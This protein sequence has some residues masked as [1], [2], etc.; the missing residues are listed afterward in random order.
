MTSFRPLVVLALAAVWLA[1]RPASAAPAEIIFLRHA[2]KPE[3]GAELNTQGWRRAAALPSLFERDPRILTHGTP[4]AIYAGAPAKA[5]GSVRSIQTMQA[6]AK[7]LHI[8][9]IQSITRDQV[10][11]LVRTILASSAYEGKTVLVCWEHKKI[12]EMIRAF[13]WVNGPAR[14]K[15]NVF[16]R[17]WI[18]DFKNGKPV[19]FQ[20][21][22][23]G[24]LPGDS[25]R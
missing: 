11:E 21:D 3:K 5:G 15:E 19:H 22:P 23:Q 6:T 16:D 10:D 24:L 9:L 14:W 20:D 7:A 18:L 8:P 2:E 1:G 13:G 12:P 17:L 25:I 4:V